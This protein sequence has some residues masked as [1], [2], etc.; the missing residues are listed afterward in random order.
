MHGLP[1]DAFPLFL[2]FYAHGD[3][4][5]LYGISTHIHT[6]LDVSS[7]FVRV[8]QCDIDR[9]TR[10]KYTCITRE[11]NEVEFILNIK[12]QMISYTSLPEEELHF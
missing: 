12:E 11:T 3:L 8:I 4:F 2:Q 7:V 10:N 6:L 5:G 1:L 9:D